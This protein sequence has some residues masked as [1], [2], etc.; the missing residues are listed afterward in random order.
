MRGA[1]GP[2]M[3]VKSVEELHVW[4]VA[5]RFVEAV[6]AVT[7]GDR[8]SRDLRLRDQMDTCADSV[9]S[10]LTEGFEQ[11]TD[12]G[13]ARYLYI[14]RGS[15]AEARAHLAVAQL[16]GYVTAETAEE[17]RKDATQIVRMLT[18]LIDYL[19]QSDRKRRR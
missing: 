1:A 10:N 19:L 15:C 18:G 14:A 8:M 13:F 4:Q 6:S 9:L 17:L 16:R 3:Q 12:R 5:W 11:G 7:R 2:H